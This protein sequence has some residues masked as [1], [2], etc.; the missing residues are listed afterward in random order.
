MMVAPTSRRDPNVIRG[1]GKLLPLPSVC[2]GGKPETDSPE[3]NRRERFNQLWAAPCF[4]YMRVL[5][6][7]DLLNMGFLL[8]FLSSI[9]HVIEC[10]DWLLHCIR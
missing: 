9:S 7:R 3:A 2:D 1:A 10:L 8:P 6:S 4:I 5:Q